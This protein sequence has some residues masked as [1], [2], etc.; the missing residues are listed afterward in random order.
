M[1]QTSEL[2]EQSQFN[3]TDSIGPI[4]IVPRV[5]MPNVNIRFSPFSRKLLVG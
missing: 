2:T 3:G 4:A 1:T 5:H